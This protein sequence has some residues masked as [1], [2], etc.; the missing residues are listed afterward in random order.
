VPSDT[1]VARTFHEIDAK[2]RAQITTA[3]A[4]VRAEVW[5]RSSA[6]TG[7]APVI[8]DIDASLVEIHTDTKEHAAPTR[9]GGF[10]F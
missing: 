4:D 6:T 1:T 2:T 3:L 8:L 9:K 10:G 7:I 5:R